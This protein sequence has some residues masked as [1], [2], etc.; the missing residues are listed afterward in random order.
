MTTTS[1]APA[2]R[3]E[4]TPNTWD[5]LMSIGGAIKAS[6]VFGSATA[7][8]AA[9]KLLFCYEN[10]LPLTTASNGLYVVNGRIAAQTNVIAA[11]LRRHPDYDYEVIDIT[12][13]GATVAIL[14]RGNDGK[15]TEAGRASFTEADAKQAGLLGKDNWKNYPEDLYFA[16][17]LSRA[18]RR[19]APDVFGQPVYTPEELSDNV[20]DAPSWQV[21]GSVSLTNGPA[22]PDL[23]ALV[24]QFGAEAVMA[25]NSGIIPSTDAE[26]AAAAEA[27][28]GTRDTEQ[29]A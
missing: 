26:V 24:E 10:G 18:Q 6:R 27:L 12:P 29:D 16:R 14:R 21:V 3:Q 5:M 23:F 17:A 9:I 7:E 25:A 28:N 2:L 11:Q 20:I 19:Y 1:T 13:K 15:L 4:L 8:E 22:K